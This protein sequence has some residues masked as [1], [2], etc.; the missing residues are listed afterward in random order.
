[1]FQLIVRLCA[2][3]RPQLEDDIVKNVRG[4]YNHVPNSAKNKAENIV[5][6][7]KKRAKEKVESVHTF[8]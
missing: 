5:A 3:L 7:I 2:Q 6:R 8:T 4:D 1:M